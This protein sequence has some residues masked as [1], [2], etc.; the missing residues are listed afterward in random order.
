MMRCVVP[1]R[2]L[3]AVVDQRRHRGCH[4][5]YAQ[6]QQTQPRG[7]EESLQGRQ[8]RLLI[9]REHLTAAVGRLLA[10][11]PVVDLEVADPPIEQ[12]IGGLFHHGT[13]PGGVA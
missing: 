1:R 2:P 11:F 8:V 6:I 4:R 3:E 5:R 13:V 10:D 7:P 9:R 12:L